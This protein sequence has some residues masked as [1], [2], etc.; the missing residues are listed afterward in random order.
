MIIRLLLLWWAKVHL[1]WATF[2]LWWW[3][4]GMPT[5]DIKIDNPHYHCCHS[6]CIEEEEHY[7][8]SLG[9]IK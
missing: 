1:W 7:D 9:E 3:T 8:P 2:V 6:G 5:T 4:R